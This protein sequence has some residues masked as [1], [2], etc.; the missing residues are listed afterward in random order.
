MALNLNSGGLPGP[1]TTYDSDTRVVIL[2]GTEI[3][4]R[5]VRLPA[6]R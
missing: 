2:S 3:L 1:G 4:A 5:G 6:T